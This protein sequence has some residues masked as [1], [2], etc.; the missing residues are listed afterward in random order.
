M[1][2]DHIGIAVKEIE[3]ALKFY[4][5][6]LGL[7]CTHIEEVENQKVKIAFL[8]VGDS[9]LELVQATSEDSAIAKFIERKGEGIQHIALRVDDIERSLKELEDKGFSLID[10]VPRIGAHESKI[11]FLHPKSAHGV[12]LELVQR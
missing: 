3:E 2:L 7:E 4:S 6:G 11:A 10:K 12:L 5:E 8:P 9:N 1:K